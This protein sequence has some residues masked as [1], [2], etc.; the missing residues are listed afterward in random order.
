[1]NR[2]LKWHISKENKKK[3]AWVLEDPSNRF[4]KPLP[5]EEAYWS[6]KGIQTVGDLNLKNDAMNF[7]SSHLDASG[8]PPLKE[9]GEEKFTVSAEEKAYSELIRLLDQGIKR[10]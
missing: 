8:F 9:F 2:K 6:Q 5:T 7:G 1:M 10:H 4:A 3:E